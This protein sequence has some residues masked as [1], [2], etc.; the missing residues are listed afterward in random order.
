MQDNRGERYENPIFKYNEIL[1]RRKKSIFVITLFCLVVYSVYVYTTP[2]VFESQAMIQVGSFSAK[3]VDIEDSGTLVL[4]IKEQYTNKEKTLP[5][6]VTAEVDKR[7]GKNVIA[8]K[9]RGRTPEEAKEFLG[10]I[11]YEIKKQHDELFFKYKLSQERKVSLIKAEIELANKAILRCQEEEAWGRDELTRQLLF[12]EK[13][14]QEEKRFRL[15]NEIAE[16]NVLEGDI[17]SKPTEVVQEATK[18]NSSVNHKPVFWLVTIIFGV[19]T[20]S[21]LVLIK[22]L[23]L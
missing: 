21:L 4:K 3:Q 9:A 23:K 2:P 5:V 19:T 15:E 12:F 16:I 14:R 7:A 22:E 20:G 10:N 8:L 13:I 1:W 17:Y 18:Q 6:L 11:V